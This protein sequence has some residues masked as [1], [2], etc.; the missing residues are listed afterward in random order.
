IWKF[1]YM[2]GVSGGGAFVLVYFLC[3]ALVALP[4]M[5]AELMIGRRGRL[6][7]PRSMARLAAEEGRSR[8]WKK[9]GWI[10]VLAAF[11]ILSFYSVIGGWAIAY[12][13]KFIAGTF[14]GADAAAVGTQFDAILANPV[15]LFI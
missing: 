4:M 6:S 8:H 1:P 10:G 11:L 3:A 13:P 12:V 7:P 9:V 2:A 14:R 15:T 5:I